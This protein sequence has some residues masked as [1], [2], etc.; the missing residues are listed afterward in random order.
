LETVIAFLFFADTRG[1]RRGSALPNPCE[2]ASRSGE[3]V[4]SGSVHRAGFSQRRRKDSVASI[5]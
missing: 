3:T 2:K 5:C 4:L 1:L